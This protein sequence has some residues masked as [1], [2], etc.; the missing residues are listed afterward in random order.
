MKASIEQQ[1]IKNRMMAMS[2]ADFDRIYADVPVEQK[3]LLREFRAGYPYKE[4]KVGDTRCRYIACGQGAKTLLFLAGGF[5]RADIWFY[6]IPQLENNYRILAPDSFYLKGG[7]GTGSATRQAFLEMLTRE[8]IERVIPIG[9]S[10]GA[11]MAQMLIREYPERVEHLILSHC[12]LFDPGAKFERQIKQ[13]LWLLRVIPFS[14]TRKV[15]WRKLAGHIPPSSQWGAFSNAYFREI[16]PNINKETVVRFSQNALETSQSFVS[17]PDLLSS[18]RGQTLILNS[19]DDRLT[20]GF[21]PRLQELFPQA[22]LHLFDEGGHHTFMLFPE[23]YTAA[24]K[25]F[26]EEVT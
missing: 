14:V 9:I 16:E 13:M 12:G 6:L 4:F 26:L 22:R 1:L 15:M 21:V 25:S 24:L 8:G 3:R 20:I 2:T 19:K 23:A 10:A 17:K 18:W 7:P 5:L 11:G